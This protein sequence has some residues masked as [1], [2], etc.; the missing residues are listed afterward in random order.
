MVL[1]V[2]LRQNLGCSRLSAAGGSWISVES[3]RFV[4]A[5][6]PI[7]VVPA[8]NH[9]AL[10]SKSL[11]Y[12]SGCLSDKSSLPGDFYVR[13]SAKFRIIAP[14]LCLILAACLSAAGTALAQR[15]ISVSTT[16]RDTSRRTALVIGN[17]AYKDGPLR[18][19]VNDAR[20]MARTLRGL[21]FKVISGEDLDWRAMRRKIIKFGDEINK[22]GVGLFYFAGHGIQAHGQNYLIPVSASIKREAEVRAEGISL[23]SVLARMEGAR[24]GLNIVILDA[25]RNNPYSRS[26]RSGGSSG[27]AQVPAPHGT[28]IAYATAPGN[29]AADG[30]GNHGV[31]TEA[32]IRNLGT[33]GQTI[34]R[35]FKKVRME[36]AGKTGNKQVPWDESSLMGDFYFKPGKGQPQPLAAPPAAQPAK[37]VQMA[38]G[39]D[40]HVDQRK[41]EINRLLSE[42]DA[43]YNAG[44]LTTPKGANALERYNKV[45]FLQPL[46]RKADEGL[47]SIVGKYID[48]A[49][50]RLK[51]GDY[52]K[53]EQFLARAEKVHEGDER[54]LALRDEVHRA[55]AE[56]ERRRKAEEQARAEAVRKERE[57]K[58]AEHK[59]QEAASAAERSSDRRYS[60]SSDGVITDTRTGL[61]WYVGSDRGTTWNDAKKWVEGLTVAG[62]G[63][64]MPSRSELKG[65][66]K[67]G[68]RSISPE[69]L[70]P[71]FKTS[72]RFV[73]SGETRGSSGAWGLYFN[74]D[75][76]YWGDRS[77]AGSLSRAFAV[78]SISQTTI[79]QK[80]KA[81][82]NSKKE[83]PKT[84]NAVEKSSSDGRYT[85]DAQGVITDSRTGLQ[86]YAGPDKNINWHDAKKWVEGLTVDGG[87]WRMPSRS[88]LKGL[89]QKGKGSRNM[90]PIFKTSGWWVWSG[91]TRGS[92]Y[93]WYFYF[94]I[95]GEHWDDRDE[96]YD[97]RV[98][99]AR[100]RR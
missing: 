88:E 89:Y 27:L 98:F 54:V 3:G 16:P 76:G 31:Y 77:Y 57:R 39:P 38:G 59:R 62:G 91:D 90:D 71:I 100:S 53:A 44:K 51:A 41:A 69:Y 25:C 23:E 50:S 2:G 30:S 32:L 34:E 5:G 29:V 86:W 35:T 94:S 85:K 68:A 28:F 42:A 40:D 60:K 87:G 83:P 26:F 10:P 37:P 47:K 49:R 67:K 82:G 21:G 17:G 45:L 64:R 72:G 18:N 48:W 66:S 12:K 46:N 9:P 7:R 15:G 19:P 70:P 43:L 52:A 55:K 61:Q 13:V 33:P 92:S 14:A 56:A 58:K 96:G 6:P 93:A 75:K 99:A 63:W 20:A 73:W 36:V 1:C 4:L 11:C 24:N 8:R 81:V 74:L 84:T 79:S 78:R 22:G 97:S 95:G 65:I 80:S